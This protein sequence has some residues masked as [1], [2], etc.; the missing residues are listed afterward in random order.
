MG[1][2]LGDHQADAAESP[3]DQVGATIAQA[4]ACVCKWI[5]RR[6]FEALLEELV[7]AQRERVAFGGAVRH[8]DQALD[9]A[10]ALRHRL[11]VAKAAAQI[12]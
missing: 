9:Q 10:V 2:V 11:L 7:L 6:A 12:R 5:E 8:T 4:R 3:G 1:E